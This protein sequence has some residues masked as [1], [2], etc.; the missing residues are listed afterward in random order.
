MLRNKKVVTDAK[1]NTRKFSNEN[2]TENKCALTTESN[3]V[4][5]KK[6]W[7]KAGAT[8]CVPLL[9]FGLGI[10]LSHLLTN[11]TINELQ[12]NVSTLTATNT[13]LEA[14]SSNYKNSIENDYVLLDN[15]TDLQEKYTA[16][17]NDYED[18]KDKSDSTKK[19]YDKLVKTVAQEKKG[20]GT[21]K[22]NTNDVR[23]L[24][25]ATAAD[26]NK[27]LEGTWLS[28]YGETFAE[29][30]KEYGVNALFSIGNAIIESGW[31]GDNYLATH[32]NN[33]YGMTL[34]HGFDT[35]QDCIKFWFNL[36]S[37]HYVDD[38]LISVARINEKYCP[39]N[40]RWSSDIDWIVNKLVSKSDITF[41]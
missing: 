29:C 7:L 23:V 31:E 37:K 3:K 25:G 12:G 5:K 16:L 19:K 32:K 36:I 21:V 8:V 11:D 22:Y 26:L 17:Q 1:L 4:D 14:L 38:G 9:T 15:Y 24:S 10:G 30:E 34:N 40:A 18:L 13:K 2:E 39:P 20:T 27:L 6:K 33:I 41:E 28:G 35:K